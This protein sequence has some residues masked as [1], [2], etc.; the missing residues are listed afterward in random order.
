MP[1]HSVCVVQLVP[2]FPPQSFFWNVDILMSVEDMPGSIPVNGTDNSPKS[3]YTVRIYNVRL[4]ATPRG[5][6]DM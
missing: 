4:K 3:I 2:Q 6:R 1:V 5:Q